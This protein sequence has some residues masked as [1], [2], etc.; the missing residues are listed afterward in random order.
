MAQINT[1]NKTQS[2]IYYKGFSTRNMS[3]PGSTPLIVN[4]D[5]VNDDLMNHIWT[6]YY[7]RPH[8][9]SFGTRIPGLTFEPNDAEVLDI[10]REDLTAVF[11]YDPRVLLQNLQI[12]AF[13]DNNA[14][15]AIATLLY[16]E[17]NV[18]GD[19]NIEIYSQ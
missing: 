14:I 6:E 11:N 8:M 5:C 3:Q 13:P 4:I 18:V 19:L 2:T 12:L 9:P 16:I 15:V 7:Q 17:L 10:I 1:K